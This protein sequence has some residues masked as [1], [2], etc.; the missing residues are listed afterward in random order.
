VHRKCSPEEHLATETILL[1]EQ[2]DDFV[3]KLAEELFLTHNRIFAG[4][5]KETFIRY[6][7]RSGATDTKIRLYRRRDGA[8]VGYAVVHCYQEVIKDKPTT[9]F[10]AEA[11]FLPQ[12]RAHGRTFYF[13]G[14]EL[15]KYRLS[16]PTENIFYLGMLVHPSSY[17]VFARYFD[18]MYPKNGCDIPEDRYRLMVNMAD[19]FAVPPVDPS[20]PLIRNIGWRTREEKL[21]WRSTNDPDV[22]FFRNR[23][24]EYGLGHGLVILVPITISNLARA[25]LV[26]VY[27]HVKQRLQE[28]Q[29]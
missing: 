18:E 17:V 24:P 27:K 9:I 4:L 28:W 19:F 6:L 14:L 16:H 13:Y 15:L 26:Y 8:L 20:D 21:Y 11:G 22:T 25:Y 3:S 23:N 29:N 10:R 2:P 7:F 1:Q 12:Y 5:D